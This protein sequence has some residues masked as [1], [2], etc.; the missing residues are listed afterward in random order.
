MPG[1]ELEGVGNSGS[2][3]KCVS[4]DLVPLR[5]V[6]TSAGGVELEHISA[7]IVKSWME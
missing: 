2:N 4:A 7:R 6:A 1:A 5:E 3:V